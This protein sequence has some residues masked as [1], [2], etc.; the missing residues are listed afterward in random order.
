MNPFLELTG[1]CEGS[2]GEEGCHHQDHRPIFCGLH[3]RRALA[4]CFGTSELL[5][6]G[7]P[8]GSSKVIFGYKIGSIEILHHPSCRDFFLFLSI[9]DFRL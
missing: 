2:A 8:K 7:T 4:I 9:L 5:G 3:P 1:N 6:F